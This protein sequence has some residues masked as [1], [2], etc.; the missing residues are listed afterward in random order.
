MQYPI[1]MLQIK[2]LQI[3][4]LESFSKRIRTRYFQRYFRIHLT[5]KNNEVNRYEV[6]S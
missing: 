3:K 1:G 6:R 5:Y 4:Q 2:H